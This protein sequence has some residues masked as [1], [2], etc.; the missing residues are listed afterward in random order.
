MRLLET[1]KLIIVQQ[2]RLIREG[3]WSYGRVCRKG[4]VLVKKGPLT[5]FTFFGVLGII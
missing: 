2:K 3:S 4:V 1:F 5:Y